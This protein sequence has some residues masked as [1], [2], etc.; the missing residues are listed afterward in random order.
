MP[1]SAGFGM[2]FMARY[3]EVNINGK[4][5]DWPTVAQGISLYERREE[6]CSDW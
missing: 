3:K 5:E 6:E 2:A 1:S 4:L